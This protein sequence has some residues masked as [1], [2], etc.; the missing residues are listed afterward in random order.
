M[1]FSWRWVLVSGVPL[2]LLLYCGLTQVIGSMVCSRGDV[3]AAFSL[4]LLVIPV[5]LVFAVFVL[6]GARLLN[7]TSTRL[8]ALVG[9]V[10]YLLIGSLVYLPSAF[11]Y[12]SFLDPFALLAVVAWPLAP[13]VI[14][15]IE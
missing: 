9:A 2:L 15:C 4:I 3:D 13:A 5:F 10:T 12:G 14:P 1:S 11:L 8:G 7:H 6:V